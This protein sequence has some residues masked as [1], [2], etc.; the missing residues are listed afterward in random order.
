ME[1]DVK[2]F[3]ASHG[4][5]ASVAEVA[6]IIGESEHD[7]RAWARANGVRRLG[8]TIAFDVSSALQCADDLC[9]EADEDDLGDEDDLDDEDAV[10]NDDN[11]DNDDLDDDD[12]EDE[13]DDEDPD[14]EEE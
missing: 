2:R 10:D 4:G 3:F 8:S 5:V 7:V 6:G 14:G 13:A 12:V 1:R 9:G 11:D